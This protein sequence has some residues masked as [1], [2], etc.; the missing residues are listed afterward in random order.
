MQVTSV[1]K[2]K[3]ERVSDFYDQLG[4]SQDFCL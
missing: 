1:E 4:I 2:F 3:F